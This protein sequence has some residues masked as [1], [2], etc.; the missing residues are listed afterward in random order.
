MHVMMRHRKQRDDGE[1]GH[2]WGGMVAQVEGY[3][4]MRRRWLAGLAAVGEGGKG[5][6]GGRGD[7]LSMS[8]VE[9][10]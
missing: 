8:C 9:L 10:F 3:L 7:Y 6:G 5:D 4:W 2:R 1:R